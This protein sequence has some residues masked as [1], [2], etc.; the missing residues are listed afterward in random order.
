MDTK[1]KVMI[2]LGS[3]Y[4]AGCIPCFD[5]YYML[6]KEEQIADDDIKEIIAIAK[7]VRNGSDIALEKAISDVIDGKEDCVKIDD[8][9]HPCKC[10]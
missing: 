6:A 4:A 9:S 10:T 7:K 1:I 3:S 8:E 5:H 2:S